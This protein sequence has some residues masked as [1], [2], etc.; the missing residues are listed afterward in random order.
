MI[1]N[2]M[3]NELYEDTKKKVEKRVDWRPSLQWKTSPWAEHYDDE[4]VLLTSLDLLSGAQGKKF[5]KG[6]D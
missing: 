2:I 4:V 1:D 3:I 6:C 5:E